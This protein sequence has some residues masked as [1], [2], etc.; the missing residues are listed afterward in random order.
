[1][2][3]GQIKM[4]RSRIN[5]YMVNNLSGNPRTPGTVGIFY[6]KNPR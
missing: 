2:G 5:I 4:F 6:C 1:M 3:K